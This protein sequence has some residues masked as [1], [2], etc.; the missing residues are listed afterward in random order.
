MKI[1]MTSKNGRVFDV[2]YNSPQDST[3]ALSCVVPVFGAE[4]T[5]R[6]A[7]ESLLAQDMGDELEIVIVNDASQDMCWRIIDGYAMLHPDITVV[8]H[9]ENAGYGAS[10]NDGIQAARGQ[11][12][13]ILEPDD[14]LRPG[15]FKTA[16]QAAEDAHDIDIVKTPYIREVRDEGVVRGDAPRALLQCSYKGRIHPAANPFSMED[17]NAV[18]LLRHHPSIWSAIY[19]KSFLDANDIEFVEY[20]G[21][22]WADNEFF[23]KTLLSATRILYL[24]EPYYVY[25]EETDEEFRAFTTKNP[26]LAFDRWHSMKNIIE[27]LDVE[28]EGVLRSHISKGFTYL[29][30][31]VDTLG[32]ES[33]VVA[34]ESPLM[35]ARMEG[36]LV[37]KE[38]LVNPDLKKMYADWA[39]NEMNML[40]AKAAHAKNLVAETAYAMKNNGPAFTAGQI[41]RY[42][43][44]AV[45]RRS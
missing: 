29:G 21:A 35:F 20:P 16:L 12:I 6:Q 36:D 25:R 15:F 7:L 9:R 13:A 14:Y 10:M 34:T 17:D 18:H 28:S 24:D 26:H 30:G 8:S 3:Y 5:L 11:W 1:E 27:E 44:S 40:G 33:A 42:V 39:G 32:M 45:R 2:E 43:V 37:E 38:D 23:Y 31:V 19:D 4:K 41:G 22:G